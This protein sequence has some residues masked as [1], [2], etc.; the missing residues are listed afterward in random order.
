MLTVAIIPCYKTPDKAPLIAS[1]CLN[2]VNKVI[3]V[4]DCCPFNT[5]DK[6]E[7]EIE[8]KNIYVIRHQKNLGVGGALKTGIIHALKIKAD[9]IVK[10]DSDGQMPPELIPNLINPIKE[11]NFYF[12]KGN[13]FRDSNIVK[14]M[15]ALRLVGNVFLSFLTKLSTGYWELFDPTNGFIAFRSDIIKNIDL[16]KIDNRYFFETDLL[17]RC[18]I[19]EILIHE[20]PMNA[21]YGEEVSNMYPIFEIPNFFFKHI[22]IFIKRIFY[23]YFLYDF[24]PG[25]ISFIISFLF[26]M[27]A[28]MLAGISYFY[29]LLNTLETPSGI[30]TLFLAFLLISSNFGINFIYYDASQRPLFRKLRSI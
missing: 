24:N 13:R 8:N 30:Q 19:N 5:G 15:P 6:I 9:I 11:K 7:S 22:L 28:I 17:F 14:K 23:H 1:K 16:R 4:D 10:I 18:S 27:A 3:C 29:A 12:S 20:I 26:G 21:I 2:Y 25:S